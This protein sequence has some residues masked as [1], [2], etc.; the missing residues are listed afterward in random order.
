[1]E[2]RFLD[3]ASVTQVLHHDPFEQLRR[4]A[5]IPDTLRVHHDNWP[6]SAHAQTGR[7]TSLH[8]PRAEQEPFT[9]KEA[10]ELCVQH[11][12]FPIG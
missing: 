6:A 11:A 8:A 7:F 4:D 12:P 10:R 5:G 9:L 1:M 2:Y 3:D